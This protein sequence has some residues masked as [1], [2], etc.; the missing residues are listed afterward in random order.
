MKSTCFTAPLALCATALVVLGGCGSREDTLSVPAGTSQLI[1]KETH[2]SE[3]TLAEGG[4]LVASEGYNLTLTVDGV[5]T[6]LKPGTYE[7]DVVLTPTE[8]V[9]QDYNDMGVQETYHYRTALYVDNGAR[10]AGKSVAAAVVGGK[11]TNSEA[12]DIAITSNEENFNGI[13]VT[14]NSKY[15]IKNA[16]ITFNGNG[17]NDFAGYGAAIKTDGTAQVTVDKATINNTGVVRTAVFV[18][19]NSVTTVNNSTIE[20]K[21]GILPADYKGGPVT[22]SGGVMMEPPWVLGIVG[23]V[24]ATNVVEYGTA[25]YNNS[26]IRTQGWGALSTDAT[27]DVKLYCKNSTVEALE[28]GYGAYADGKSLATF[29][30]CTIKAADYGLILTGGSGVLTDKSVVTAG[31]NAVMM[32]SGGSGTLTV[33]KDSELNAKEAV[34]QIKSSYPKIVVNKATLKSDSGVIVEAIIND[35]PI[36]ATMAARMA[37]QGIGASDSLFS[38]GGMAPAGAPA[39]GM[40]PAGGPP[41]AGDMGA[42]AGTP[43]P[44]GMASGPNP[45]DGPK[46]ITALFEDTTLNGDIINSMSSLGGMYVVL[47]NSTI[48]G[49]IST[50]TQAPV[51]GT[52]TK[53]TYQLIGRMKHTY[54]KTDNA[55]GLDV[56]LDGASKWVVDETSYLTGLTLGEGASISAPEGS[57]VTLSVN[58][59][60]Q[61]IAAGN[62]KGAIVVKVTKS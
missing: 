51:Q 36:A 46:V 23:N 28:S 50:A 40:A 39:G 48:T 6:A 57:T 1:D 55:K 45:A 32:H 27:K 19:G 43:P 58:G 10:V 42:P 15:S 2:L 37:A 16:R 12:S 30:G 41:P 18:A 5:G 24:R 3:L 35:D 26:T 31:R 54:G 14:G 29:N 49:S 47:Q 21:N 9:A 62:Y 61:P 7:G 4:S 56:K 33:E 17:G 44:G 53:E 13:I 60:D 25:Y 52:P 22:G 59:K 11:V 38:G 34:I 8:D 20:V